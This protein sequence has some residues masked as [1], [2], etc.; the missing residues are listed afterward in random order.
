MVTNHHCMRKISY[1]LFQKVKNKLFGSP[2]A[3]LRFTEKGLNTPQTDLA[4]SRPA[5]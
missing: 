2:S 5:R 1:Q 4:L 3:A